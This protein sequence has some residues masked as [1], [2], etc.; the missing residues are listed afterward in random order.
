V[1]PTSTQQGP[2]GIHL[3]AAEAYPA[4]EEAFLAAET[5][6]WASFLVFDLKTRLRSDAAGAVGRTW[7][8][9]LVHVLRR[10]VAIN[11]VISDADPIA[12]PEMHRDATRSLRMFCAAAE[13]AGPG[14]R[15]NIDVTRHPGETGLALRALIWPYIQRKLWKSAGKLNRL[16]PE[17]RTAAL[18]DM[19][20]LVANMRIRPDGKVVP[21]LWYL[22]RLFPATHH[23][24]LAVFD[25]RLLYIGGLDLDER[26]YDTPEHRQK[27]SQT[28]HDLQLTLE[29]PAVAEAQQHLEQFRDIVGGT[30]V[31][32]T[33]RRLLVTVSRHRAF[34]LFH[35]GPEPVVSAIVTGHAVLA[36]RAQRLIYLESQYFRDSGFARHLARMARQNPQLTLIL[37]LPAA[38]DEVAFDKRQGLDSRFGEALQAR[39]LRTIR[40]A[41][42]NRLFVG[43]PAQQRRADA[44]TDTGTD[45]DGRD[46]LHGAPLVYV[47]AKVS[48][49]DDQSAIVSS[50][51]LNGRSFYWDTE[52]GVYLNKSS[53][54]A[55][56][57]RRVMA[58][59]LP[60]DAGPEAFAT[61]TAAKTWGIIAR[62]NARARPE[63]RKGFLL[64]HDFAAA[65][66]FGRSV[67]LIPE[68]MA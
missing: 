2:V 25:R 1:K 14:A 41:F 48:L 26:R 56:L 46:S 11:F 62:R 65:E 64:P 35:F 36:Q 3:T 4:L 22:P 61:E 39:A 34:N 42:G 51:N 38:P 53:D 18:R 7:F 40:K 28:W 50:A 29:G 32:R 59:W 27:G 8:D 54:V 19:P 23:Q 9:L 68:E 55:D 10:G 12:R 52:A 47:H 44:Q 37:I 49:F 24:K 57:R 60:E 21:C 33:F 5:E 63:D 20:G 58:H 43:S 15:L 16:T 66:A 17:H 67:P 30:K 45:A 6:I 13:I 31:A